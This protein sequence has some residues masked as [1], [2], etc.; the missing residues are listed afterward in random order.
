M[1]SRQKLNRLHLVGDVGLAA[2]AGV[3]I[4]SWLAFLLA[5]IVLVGL[6]IHVGA[7]RPAKKN[8]EEGKRSEH[9]SEGRR[10]A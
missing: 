5:L 10:R 8:R 6:D 2:V 4:G 1:G 9:L 3:V 7:I